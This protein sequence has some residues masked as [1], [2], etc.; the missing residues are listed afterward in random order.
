MFIKDYKNYIFIVVTL[1][2]I[3]SAVL[4]AKAAFTEQIN[5]QGKL[6]SSSNVAV[7]DGVKCIK[8]RLM[9]ALSGGSELCAEEWTTSS[10]NVATTTNGL[11]SVLLGA[12]TTLS[13]VDFNQGLYL[14]VQFD[15]G[16]DG[17][18]EE[19]F[20]PRKKIGA[21]PARSEERRVGKECRSRWSPY[22]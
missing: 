13:S 10:S 15:P 4:V 16:C 1:A 20:S 3:T 14:E 2:V 18:Y 9:T 11:F 12:N 19:V 17:T 5:Y 21:D 7:S 22:H 8:F 6:T